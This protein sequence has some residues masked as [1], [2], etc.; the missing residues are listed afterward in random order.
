M[1]VFECIKTRRAV[2][3]FQQKKVTWENISLI[4]DA[5]RLAPSS[6]NLQN[7]KFIVVLDNEKKQAVAK[8]CIKQ[9][10]VAEAPV[11]IAII[12]EPVKAERF[13]GDRGKLYTIQNCAAATQNMLLE[14]HNIG[15]SSCWVSAFSEEKLRDV[16][17]APDDTVPYAIIPIGYPD[18][19]SEEPTKFPIENVT[20]FNKWRGKIKNV[21]AYLNY[22]SV[23][24]EKGVKKGKEII[25]E[26]SK[27]GLEKAKE[28]AKKIKA[29]LKEKYKK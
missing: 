26:Q 28:I 10:W 4:L 6:G 2:R 12:G 11:L 20:Y 7:W 14:A 18:E 27:T 9:T 24:I 5:G 16:L 23:D 17:G 8:A 15:L 21:P 22:Y 29:K 13:Y 19:E 1:E 25:E 3:S